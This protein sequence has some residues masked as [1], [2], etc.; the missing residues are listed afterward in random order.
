MIRF[1]SLVVLLPLLMLQACVAIDEGE[2]SEPR[3]YI[4]PG[5]ASGPGGPPFSGAVLADD[6]LYISG[7]LGLINGQVPDDPA[8]EARA[9][10]DSIRETVEAAGLTMNDLVHVTVYASD[11]SDY[12]VFNQVYRSYFTDRFPARAFIGA[13]SLLF[14]ARFE[15]QAIAAVPED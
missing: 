4:N 14:D 7:M 5:L 10:L 6:V 12:D 9:M 3:V 15:M 1:K 13:G 11:L 8:A 2:E